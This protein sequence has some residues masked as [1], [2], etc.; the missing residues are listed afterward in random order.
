MVLCV[1]RT[2]LPGLYSRNDGMDY[3]FK[4]TK[5]LRVLAYQVRNQQQNDLEKTTSTV[6]NKT[7]KP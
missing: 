2:F 5:S 4:G 1:A 7:N 6:E 3:R